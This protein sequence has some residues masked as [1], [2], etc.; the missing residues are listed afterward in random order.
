MLNNRFCK[1]YKLGDTVRLMEGYTTRVVK[2]T[3]FNSKGYYNAW[4]ANGLKIVF[5]D[6]DIECK[7]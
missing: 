1:K 2:I 6:F 7:Y 4:G 5:S 3:S